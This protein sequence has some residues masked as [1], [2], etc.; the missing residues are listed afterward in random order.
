MHI[1]LLT[2]YNISSSVLHNINHHWQRTTCVL[3]A[4]IL[5]FS[6]CSIASV[7]CFPVHS[8]AVVGDSFY[9]Y[10]PSV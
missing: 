6:M 7:I 3:A 9:P 2:F 4:R 5:C 10:H 1:G 8:D